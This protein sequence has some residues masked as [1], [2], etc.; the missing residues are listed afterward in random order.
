MVE[1]KKPWKHPPIAN[2]STGESGRWAS[3]SGREVFQPSGEEDAASVGES[4]LA[5]WTNPKPTFRATDSELD[6]NPN[7]EVQK[8]PVKTISG[9]ITIAE[10][11][12]EE[13]EKIIRDSREEEN[14]EGNG[15]GNLEPAF[16]Q[17]TG[18]DPQESETYIGRPS[19]KN[20]KMVDMNKITHTRI[21]DDIHYYDNGSEGRGIVV[22]MG[23]AFITVAK[24]DGTFSDIHINDTFFVKDIVVNKTWDRMDASERIQ[25]LKAAKAPSPMYVTKEWDQLPT[26]L[27]DVLTKEG[28]TYEDGESKDS[29]TQDHSRTNDQNDDQK[30]DADHD[31]ATGAKKDAEF[32]P[33]TGQKKSD[34]EETALGNAGG[35]ANAGVSTNESNTVDA[36]EDYEGET[37]DNKDEEFKHEAQNPTTKDVGSTSSGSATTATTTGGV[38]FVYSDVKP[39]KT[40]KFNNVN[41]NSWGLKYTKDEDEK[42]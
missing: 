41:V 27:K 6:E 1:V 5:R 10:E 40:K 3:V 14:M 34:V 35:N 7:E 33:A 17:N 37:H 32:D 11:P 13:L 15:Y 16:N 22:K 26:E 21:G 9:D 38:N 31:P 36:P 28:F 2:P 42:A 12:D 8:E 4:E 25:A 24:D 19:K 29:E 39:Y 30:K 23:S 20:I 18:E